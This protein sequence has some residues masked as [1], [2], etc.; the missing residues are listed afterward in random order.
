MSFNHKQIIAALLAALLCATA[1][2]AEKQSTS[3][4]DLARQLNEAF[5]QVADQVSPAVVVIRVAHKANRAEFDTEENPLWDLLPPEFRRQLEQQREKQRKD[6]DKDKDKKEESPGRREPLPFDGQGSGVVI[7]EDGYI[8][9][10]RHVVDEAEKI[11]VRLKDESEFDAEV[12]GVDAQSDLAVVK[13]DTK[14]KKLPVAKLGDSDKVRVGEFAIA[15]GAPFELDYSV[16]FG[17]VSAKGR[18]RIINDPSMDQD[19]IQTDANINPG[20]SGGPLVNIY[21]E[22]IGINTLIRGLRTGI[23]FAIPSNLASEIS[24][25]LIRE[26]KFTR[27]WLGIKINSLRDEPDVRDMVSVQR[28]VVVREIVPGGPAAGSDLKPGDII[29]SVD[30]KP[31]ETPQQLKNEIR[32]KK[33]GGTVNLEVHRLD[34]ELKGKTVSVKVKP[35]A[36]RDEELQVASNRREPKSESAR[37]YGLTVQAVTKDLA[38]QFGVEKTDGVIVT[39]VERGSEAERKGIRAGDIITMVNHQAVT[40]PAQFREAMKKVDPKRGAFINFTSRNTSKFE[41][42]KESGE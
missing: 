1:P 12:R 41:V 8:L 18:S 21:G 32:A 24:E 33:I 42:L 30:G 19:F 4:L 2:A 11:K 29:L 9:T 7:R 10:N 38:E 37:S 20:N 31:V 13:I 28:G 3:A 22:V 25:I 14:G 23:G 6:K 5:I 40:N 16:T 34:K 15:I 26:G 27:A 17:H 36:W 35:D 39:E